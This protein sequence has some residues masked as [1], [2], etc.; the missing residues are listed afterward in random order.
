VDFLLDG[1]VAIEV[2]AA[3]LIQEKHTR[4]LR[5]LM[6]EGCVQR[7]IIVCRGPRPRTHDGIEILPWEFFLMHLWSDEI[8]ARP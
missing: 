4:G 8:V 7:A 6:E 5:A 1:T 3:R 2:K